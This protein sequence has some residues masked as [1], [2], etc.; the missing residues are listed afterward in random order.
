MQ[1]NL[2][3]QIP[4]KRKSVS[5]VVCTYN[6]EKYVAQQIHTLLQQTY[7]IDE[8]I[9][10]DDHSEDHTMEILHEIAEKHP[11]VKV[12]S[13][14]ARQGI[15]YNFFSAMRKA[16]SEYIAICDQDDL[17]ASDKIER[18]MAE[19]GD[20]MLCACRSKP[21]AENGTSVNF[22]PRTPNCHLIRLLY[23]SIPGHTMLIHRR[24]LE[25]I[26]EPDEQLK[27]YYDVYLSLT[28]AAYDSLV[29]LDEV[30]VSQ[31]RHAG[32]V[33]Y[34]AS[35]PRR[36]PSAANGLY[37]LVWSIR[38]FH[39]IRPYMFPYFERRRR[40]VSSINASG[41][42]FDDAKTIVSLQCKSGAFDFLRLC[43]MYIKYRHYLFYTEGRGFVVEEL[44]K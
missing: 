30:L 31:R 13:N 43:R 15:N 6:G 12:L 2:P 16:R 4:T 14:K 44:S 21:F 27:T 8:I 5:I 23:S 42:L 19:I 26:P 17:W 3:Y 35:D 7:P 38:N 41:Q 32:A 39:R 11:H 20:K 24:L 25:L 29:L 33:T 22:D 28:A 1:Q 10:Q 18:Q 34:V 9:I 37:I 36:C 40:L